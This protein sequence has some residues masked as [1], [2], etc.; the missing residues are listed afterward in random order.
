MVRVR[1]SLGSR[2]AFTSVRQFARDLSIDYNR[3][4]RWESPGKPPWGGH[5]TLTVVLRPVCEARG[6]DPAKVAA[7][8]LTGEGDPPL[9]P[10]PAGAEVRTHRTPAHGTAITPSIAQ[11]HHAARSDH[12]A[13]SLVEYRDLIERVRQAEARA[14]QDWPRFLR[15]LLGHSMPEPARGMIQAALALHGQ[16]HGPVS[17]SV[18]EADSYRAAFAVI[19]RTFRFSR[20]G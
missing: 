8:A 6:L 15:L 1:E 10:A 12:V 3:Y 16:D 14:D 9:G 13:I 17:Q 4:R 7:W 2:G 19:P 18:R 11:Q 20:A 5:E